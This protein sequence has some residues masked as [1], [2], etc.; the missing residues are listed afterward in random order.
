MIAIILPTQHADL[1]IAE[2]YA[3]AVC[4]AVPKKNP[5]AF[6]AGALGELAFAR[7]DSDETYARCQ[8]HLQRGARPLGVDYEYDFV[9]KDSYLVD[10]KSVGYDN[11]RKG[12][13]D[14]LLSKLDPDVTYVL[15]YA[16]GPSNRIFEFAG[17]ILGS[18]VIDL[19]LEPL[20]RDNKKFVR[21]PRNK[22]NPV[23]RW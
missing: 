22:L 15:L 23:S 19:K 3:L 14:L 10:V 21:V 16:L 11:V 17:W 12:F 2:S 1:D 5:E 6:Y 13:G 4:Q 7:W 18:Q 9:T 20:A 8:Q